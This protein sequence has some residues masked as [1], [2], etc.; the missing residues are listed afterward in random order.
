ME[1]SFLCREISPLRL[2]VLF[3]Q[4][5]CISSPPHIPSLSNPFF[6]RFKF[7]LPNLILVSFLRISSF[8]PS[9]CTCMAPCTASRREHAC[10][11][12]L[13]FLSGFGRFPLCQSVALRIRILDEPY[14]SSMGGLISSEFLFFPQPL[15]HQLTN[16]SSPC[17]IDSPGLSRKRILFFFVCSLEIKRTVPACDH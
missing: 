8:F 9:L 16:A 13:L 10:S 12:C 14:F 4:R 3:L 17:S 5:L 15:P 11:I 1:I 2:R 6:V 7:V